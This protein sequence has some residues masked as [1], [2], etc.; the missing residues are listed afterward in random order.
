ML[1]DFKVLV[2]G[3]I[4]HLLEL[5]TDLCAWSEE[6]EESGY[7]KGGDRQGPDNS[8][9]ALLCYLLGI[10]LQGHQRNPEGF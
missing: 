3:S 4:K 1:G 8:I 6:S 10:L 2:E 9:P 5:P 7:G